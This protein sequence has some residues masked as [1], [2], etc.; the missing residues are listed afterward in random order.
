[1]L[2]LGSPDYLVQSHVSPIDDE[3][4]V[5]E[6]EHIINVAPR[7][8]ARMQHNAHED[9]IS[10]ATIMSRKIWKVIILAQTPLIIILL[11]FQILN[12]FLWPQ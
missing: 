4:H 2:S 1:M 12:L 6:T 3:V 7:V 5:A 9:V 11:C 10:R 8:S